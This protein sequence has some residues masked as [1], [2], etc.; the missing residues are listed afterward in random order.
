M[1]DDQGDKTEEPTPKKLRDA[2]KKGQVLQVKDMASLAT[3]FVIFFIV[4]IGGHTMI[5][6]M[7]N[8]ILF[9]IDLWAA[10]GDTAIAMS[11]E[12]GTYILI[13]ATVVLASTF[14]F[15]VLFVKF[16]EVGLLFST[17]PLK[18]EFKKINPIEGFKRIYSKKSLVEFG[19]TLIKTVTLLVLVLVVYKIHIQNV[20]NLYTCDKYCL[21]PIVGEILYDYIIWIVLIFLVITVI[22]YAIQA[23]F[24]KK[25]AAL[26]CCA[27]SS[28]LF[29]FKRGFART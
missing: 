8:Y 4:L 20:L 19:K 24:F 9:S 26:G 25:R 22:D 15:T 11:L 28:L 6:G 16:A 10:D 23:H 17:E 18:I 12:I 27:N 2:R 29:M 3:F 21:F 14:I 1:A 5:E 7:M 13:V